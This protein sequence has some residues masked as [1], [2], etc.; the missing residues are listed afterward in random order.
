M[1]SGS[2]P[3]SATPF[4][5]PAFSMMDD[6]TSPFETPLDDFLSTP[7]FE[8][9]H[10]TAHHD[11]MTSPLIDFYNPHDAFASNPN[12][13]L[14]DAPGDFAMG[15]GD[16]EKPGQALP[17]VGFP[18]DLTTFPTPSHPILS[19]PQI[20]TASSSI[21]PTPELS[22][23]RD[24]APLPKRGRKAGNATGTRKGLTSDA[25]LPVEAPIQKRKYALPS[26]TSRKEVPALFRKRQRALAAPY[27]EEMSV[28]PDLGFASPAMAPSTSTSSAS[29]DEYE[30]LAPLPPT[31]SEKEQI[32][33]KRKQNTLAAR[34]SR[35]RKLEHQHE[36]E[37][38]VKRATE[39]RDVWRRRAE[40]MRAMLA[41]R[42]VEVDLGMWE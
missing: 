35:K 29:K 8:D 27:P 4:T 21:P 14:F 32:E 23:P 38:A 18:F 28:C 40:G 13:P 19:T 6:F 7:L 17:L 20:P 12:A 2:P 41:A 5:S 34:K 10:S 16:D 1:P 24:L 11:M 9:A 30:E 26:A 25:L 3:L 15:L 37:G 33:W 31:A 42:G 36:L 22:P 39:E